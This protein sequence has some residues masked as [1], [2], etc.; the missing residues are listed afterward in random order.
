MAKKPLGEPRVSLRSPEYEFF[1]LLQRLV[2]AHGDPSLRVLSES[3]EVNCTPQV[4]HRALVGPDLPSTAVVSEIVNALGCSDV[5]KS[6]VSDAFSLAKESQISR[7]RRTSHLS[8]GPDVEREPELP[9][10]RNKRTTRSGARR[11]FSEHLRGIYVR[12]G[13]PPLRSVARDARV[14]VST[15]SDWL[16]GKTFPSDVDYAVELVRGLEG[17]AGSTGSLIR[18]SDYDI[19]R[20]LYDK[21]LDERGRHAPR[22]G[23]GDV[24]PV[25]SGQHTF[26]RRVCAAHGG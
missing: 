3:D 26:P 25:L 16:N 6:S 14:S 19:L 13:S 4:L 7:Q 22:S 21:V 9:R 10:R 24:R 1:D 5:D 12:A 15:V 20:Y 8:P 18:R 11:D 2:R 17:R 23:D